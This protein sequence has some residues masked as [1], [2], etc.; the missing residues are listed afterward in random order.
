MRLTV[1][2][3]MA[4][5]RGGSRSALPLSPTLSLPPSLSFGS[6]WSSSIRPGSKLFPGANI[7]SGAFICLAAELLKSTK[8]GADNFASAA[9]PRPNPLPPASFRRL[10]VTE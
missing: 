4:G 5:V 3:G 9:T 6:I 2:G 1:R 7:E 8:G 10:R